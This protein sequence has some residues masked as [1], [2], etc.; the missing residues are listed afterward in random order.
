M[1][2]I[3]WSC[4]VLVVV[5]WAGCSDRNGPTTPSVS[6]AQIG[7]YTVLPPSG[8]FTSPTEEL[9]FSINIQC[10]GA[11]VTGVSLTRDDGQTKFL[12]VFLPCQPQMAEYHGAGTDLFVSV[13]DFGHGGHTVSLGVVIGADVESI[14]AGKIL[15][16][17]PAL[18][19]WQV[20]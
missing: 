11:D 16:R 4:V 20:P 2:R 3:A 8:P 12:G 17:S 19:T 10:G 1:M 15:Y 5:V 6:T 14:Q 18:A 7:S 13:T 9:A